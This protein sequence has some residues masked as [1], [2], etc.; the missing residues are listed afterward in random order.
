MMV[1]NTTEVPG[2]STAGNGYVVLFNRAPHP[3]AAKLFVNWLLSSRLLKNSI[4]PNRNYYRYD[5]IL[6]IFWYEGKSFYAWRRPTAIGN[7]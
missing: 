5:T 7:V 1:P 2:F 6:H 4:F 3:N